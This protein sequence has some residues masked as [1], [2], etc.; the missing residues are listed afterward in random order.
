MVS[1]SFLCSLDSVEFKVFLAELKRLRFL[2]RRLD[3]CSG[4]DSTG[5]NLT[6]G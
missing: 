5:G 1:T 3:V 4:F 6:E 2:F